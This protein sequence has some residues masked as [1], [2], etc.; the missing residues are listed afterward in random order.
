MNKDNYKKV[1]WARKTLQL[2]EEATLNEIKRSY[3]KLSLKYHP[4]RCPHSRKNECKEKFQEITR[5]YE[6]I[7]DYCEG[8]KYSFK[9]ESLEENDPQ[10]RYRQHIKRFYGDWFASMG[11]GND[12]S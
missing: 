1:Q 3:K 8:Y 4:D 11:D 12:K 9:K 10:M 2:P 6:I 5:A 7:M